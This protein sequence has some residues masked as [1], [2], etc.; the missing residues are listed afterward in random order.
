MLLLLTTQ[1]ASGQA[2]QLPTVRQFTAST[3]VSVPDRGS[4]QLGGVRRAAVGSTS[5]GVPGLGRM[6]GAGRLFKN[7]AIGSTS[8][9]SNLRV[10]ATI[11]DLNEM[12]QAILAAAAANRPARSDE[13]NR[14][15]GKAGFL[16]RNV[17]H[18]PRDRTHRRS[19]P[20]LPSVKQV[21][22]DNE[23]ALRELELEAA[24]YLKKAKKAE[25]DERP[26][27]AKIYYQMVARRTRGSQKTAILARIQAIDDAKGASS[28]VAAR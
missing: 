5:R 1:R 19:A 15:A 12:D 18:A 7:R 9:V 2:V 27:L 20:A 22:R 11:I 14:L 26:G 3:T 13:E 24:E 21:Q 28:K 25:S 10:H 17:A 6:P 8:S 16:S 23:I 4:A